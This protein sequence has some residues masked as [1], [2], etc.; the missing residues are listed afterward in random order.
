M[1]T[2]VVVLKRHASNNTRYKYQ[3]LRERLRQAVI[4]GEL[5]GKLPGERSL[6][7]RYGANAKTINKALSDLTTE[8]LLVRHVGR[9]T[10]VAG[11]VPHSGH[12]PDKPL[13]FLWL[14]THSPLHAQSESIY[15]MTASRLMV[16]DHRLERLENLVMD[17]DGTI[18]G[19]SLPP[20]ATRDLDGVVIYASRPSIDLLA[21]LH[22]RHIPSILINCRQDRIKAPMVTPDYCQGA[23]E[24]CEQ[25]IR[26]GHRDVRLLVDEACEVAL[27]PAEIGYQAA[28]TRHG[29][30]GLPVETA[31]IDYAW[32]QLLA[33]PA[34]GVALICVGAGMAV[35]AI[36]EGRRRGFTSPSMLSI[37]ALAEPGDG[38]LQARMVTG[39]EFPA[40]DVSHWTAELLMT[41]SPG[42]LPRT[43]IVP[44][45]FSDR[46][47]AAPPLSELL[48]QQES[49]R[50]VM[51]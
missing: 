47:S 49:P 36:E 25:Q 29:L 46:G 42:Q 8:G 31:G 20:S 11:H 27:P 10:F 16:H 51:V 38:L 33:N 19:R 43:V 2:N 24:L 30:R 18:A 17:E 40:E 15:Q 50:E 39:Y 28:M 34:R 35:H 45:R 23:F 32:D 41:A 44:G 13:R 5:T 3:R 1:N 26:L 9:G 37:N 4:D 12:S 48:P 21:D 22:R 6:A 14:S 7:R